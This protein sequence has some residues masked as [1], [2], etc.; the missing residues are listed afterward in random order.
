MISAYVGDPPTIV[1]KE[2]TMAGQTVH[3]NHSKSTSF[4]SHFSRSPVIPERQSGIQPLT[5]LA[6]RKAHGWWLLRYKLKQFFWR[7]I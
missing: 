3:Q 4:V 5:L 7:Q 1:A 2:W 6:S